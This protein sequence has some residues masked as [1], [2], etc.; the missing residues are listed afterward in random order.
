M[1]EN[2]I[3][4]IDTIF[5]PRSIAVTGA[6]DKKSSL[7]NMLPYNFID[8]GFQGKIYPINPDE[9]KVMGLKSY[10]NLKSIQDPVDLLVVS[11]HP[12]K[13]PQV[14]EEAVEKHVKGA[15]VFTSGYREQGEEGKKR[16]GE[17]VR[18]A[19]KGNLRIIGPNCMGLYCPSSKLSFIPGLSK[20]SGPIA[21]ISQ[22]GSLA[23]YIAM[24][25][26][27]RGLGSSSLKMNSV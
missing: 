17:L 20:E 12:E 6:S 19:R 4:R 13:V 26:N 9:E 8:I 15:I 1:P 5:N 10:L 3:S 22:S 25:G 2:L 27:V 24:A 7:G 18:I 23:M 14:I 11:L 21:F 16:Q